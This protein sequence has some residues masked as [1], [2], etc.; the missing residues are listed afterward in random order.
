[1][2]HLVLG[3]SAAICLAA[4]GGSSTSPAVAATPQF[5]GN[6]A[7]LCTPF[8][9]RLTVTIVEAGGATGFTINSLTLTM[10]DIR[11]TVA[12]SR[13]YSPADLTTAIASNHINAGQ[14]KVLVYETAYPGTVDTMDSTARI[15]ASVTDDTGHT[16]TPVVNV[17]VQH[18]QC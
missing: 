8:R 7:R 16:T 9:A 15:E 2:R 13:I 14:T 18:D 17:N 11:G 6:F 10:I 3:I 12:A 5:T 4:C 1:M